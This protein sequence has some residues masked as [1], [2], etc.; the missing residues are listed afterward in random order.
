MNNGTNTLLVK[1]WKSLPAL[2]ICLFLLAARFVFQPCRAFGGTLYTPANWMLL[3]DCGYNGPWSF[4]RQSQTSVSYTDPSLDT[5]VFS[6]YECNVVITGYT[7]SATMSLVFPSELSW[8]YENEK[9]LAFVKGIGKKAFYNK[10]KLLAVAI[11]NSPTFSA[12]GSESFRGCSN[13]RNAVI[14]NGVASIGSNAFRGCNSLTSLDMSTNLVA[15]GEQAFRGCSSLR[16]VKLISDADYTISGY[17]LLDKQAF[18]GCTGLTNVMISNKWQYIKAEVFRD[19]SGLRRVVIGDDNNSIE[20]GLFSGCTS[21]SSVEVP[22][23]WYGTTKLVDQGLPDGCRVTYRG[24]ADAFIVSNITVT[25]NANGGTGISSRTK[26]CTIGWP[27]GSLPTSTREGYSLDGWYTSASGGTRVASGNK[28]TTNKS[29]TLYAHWKANTYN[30]TFDQQGGT[31][32]TESIT[33]TYESPMPAIVMPSRNGYTFDGYYT[34]KGGSGTQYYTATGQSVRTWDQPSVATLYA[35]WTCVVTLDQQDG[36]GG[37]ASITATYGSPMPSITVPTRSGFMFG[38]YYTGKNGGG[39]QYYTAVGEST[40]AWKEDS[41]TTLYA[42]WS[43]DILCTVTLDQQGGT[44]GV[45]SITA[46]Y[47]HAMPTVGIPTRT[48]H[49]F[50]GYYSEANGGGTQYY[51]AE[52]QSARVWDQTEART[53]YA[54]WTV[55]TYVVTLDRQGGRGGTEA[56]TATYASEMPTI[57]LPM[58]RGYTFGG[59]YSEANGGGMQYYTAAGESVRAWDQPSAATLFAQWISNVEHVTAKYAWPWGAGIRYEVVGTIQP[60]ERLVI[61]AMD[62]EKNV[63]YSAEPRTLSGD[64]GR[65]AGVH[66]VLWELDKQG[67]K[68]QS[69]NVV[70]AV[71]YEVPLLLYCVVDLSAGA[72]AWSYPVT[73]MNE[74]PSGGFNTDEY[75][76]TK[77]VLRRIEAGTFKM[78]NTG[79]VT[80]SQPFYVGLF[81]VTQKQWQLVMG[82]TPSYHSG[83]TRPVEQVSYATIRGSSKGANWPASSEVDADSFVGKLQARTGLNFDL[84]TEAQWEYVCRAGTTTRFS[85]GDSAN[86]DYM[87]YLNNASQVTH[88]VGQKK[89]NPWGLYD[90]HGNVWEKCL[91]RYGTLTY[92]TDPKGP[93]SGASCVERGGSAR[94]YWYECDSSQR[95]GNGLGSGTEYLNIGFRLSWTP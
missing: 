59:Y 29:H 12:I 68:I 21:L 24:V 42:Q 45:A 26:T 39:T 52:G 49:T 47:G 6:H 89:A 30:V 14:G 78:Q 67:V 87:W 46:I 48:G 79:N 90:M 34:E 40:M 88:P 51:T 75:K 10:T 91:D 17:P 66:H 36:A 92:G 86:G 76:T 83:D 61:T 84:P 95:Q 80:L 64:T 5:W 35:K 69:T 43:E 71:E 82:T 22:G 8:S 77:L 58:R 13:L 56:V 41:T 31:G 4:E 53:L 3:F 70:F 25:F 55:N 81:E 27:Y 94:R 85:Y 11:P 18:M 16:S 73:Y 28:V 37:T 60:D 20:K 62:R 7:G 23:A 32:G 57:V 93:S 50:G 72:N 54:K 2:I 38:G 33:A 19:C 1:Q 65:N 63:V 15:I 9:Y 44:G 74:P